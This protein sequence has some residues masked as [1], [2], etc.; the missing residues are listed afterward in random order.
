MRWIRLMNLSTMAMISTHVKVGQVGTV[1]IER[2]V[3]EVSELLG[4]GV[5]VGHGEDEER[6]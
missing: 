2:R 5:D 6:E 3:V 1:C 4:D